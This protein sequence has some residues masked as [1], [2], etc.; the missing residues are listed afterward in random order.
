M[1]AGCAG[2][3]ASTPSGGTESATAPAPPS[4]TTETSLATTNAPCG[5]RAFLPV[6][7]EQFDD[8]A[9]E[10]RIV[11]ADVERCRNDYAQ[12]FAVPDQSGCEPGVARCLETEQVFLGWNGAR[13]RV[14]TSGT[15]ISCEAGN[16]TIALIQRVCSALGYPQAA[17]FT[18]TFQT[19]SQNIGCAVGGG[20]L[21]CDILSGL[22]P[23]P[24]AACELD[25]VGIVLEADGPAEPQCAG[26]TAYDQD[27][28]TLAYGET[29]QRSAFTCESRKTGLRCV[30]VRGDGFSLARARWSTF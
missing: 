26:D 13:W 10:L 23:E 17:L 9:A 12:V 4:V 19:P 20:A 8:D 15:G 22:T 7:K 29:W 21:R 1:A 6:L 16:E 14:L 28:P 3:K 11:R 27:A 2:E 5:P 25:W 24:D 18:R 30:N